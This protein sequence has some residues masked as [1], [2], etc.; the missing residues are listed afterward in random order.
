MMEDLTVLSY[1]GYGKWWVTDPSSSDSILLGADIYDMSTH[2]YPP[3]Q[4]LEYDY[5][6]GIV[7]F[8]YYDDVLKLQPR[9]ESD[10][11]ASI[12]PPPDISAGF[13]VDQ[14][15]LC[16]M[17]DRA[18]DETTAENAGNYTIGS[19]L[20]VTAAL[21]DEDL[22]RVFLS[23]NPAMG[24][25]VEDMAYVS[26]VED[27]SGIAIVSDSIGFWQGFTPISQFQTLTTPGDDNTYPSDMLLEVV[28]I[29][30]V[31]V[32]DTTA[33]QDSVPSYYP[34]NNIYINDDSGP[35]QNGVLC[36]VNYTY[37]DTSMH[38]PQI[39]DEIV[40]TAEIQEYYGET[41]LSNIDDYKNVYL[42]SS[43]PVPDPGYL[44]YEAGDFSY[45]T[46]DATRESFE[47]VLVKLCDSLEVVAVDASTDTARVVIMSLTDAADTIAFDYKYRNYNLPTV[48]DRYDG[49]TGVVR[50]RWG[51]WRLQPRS[52]DDFNTGF[53]CEP[54]G[55][56]E[57]LP[58]DANM[59]VGSWPPQVIGGDVTYMVGYF[60]GI[61]ASCLVSGFY[62]SA[63][64]NADCQVIGSDVTRLVTYFR[65]LADIE[66]CDDYPPAWPTT[67]DLP[68][69]APSGWPNCETPPV[70][71]SKD[72]P[73]GS[74][75]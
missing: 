42:V 39:G 68:G 69:E 66:P 13:P 58:G 24:N 41:E 36:Y 51:Y 29:K 12:V 14:S 34:A 21:L 1:V 27:T 37:W 72:L 16:L 28:T 4:G 47:G 71:S 38:I 15:T 75:K 10:M 20:S 18:L 63:D 53:N 40:M 43:G 73:S 45:N 64:V 23:L 17:F 5:V 33:F 9:M 62:C 31:V 70:T 35:P 52:I 7:T 32:A 48:G 50:W 6:V 19:G 11:E 25:G 54:A 61:N 74:T 57:Y 44:T 55:E 65:G 2:P 46:Y 59:G 26:G 60:R 22:Q 49:L 8:D 56:N 3:S 30:G 67:E